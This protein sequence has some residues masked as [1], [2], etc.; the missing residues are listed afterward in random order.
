MLMAMVSQEWDYRRLFF[1]C[2]QFLFSKFDAISKHRC[3]NSKAALKV[4]LADS[5]LYYPHGHV[6][7]T[8]DAELAV[9][10]VTC[11]PS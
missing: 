9:E 11:A 5:F 10:S 6:F 3:S 2:V 1:V 4:Y 8:A 7:V